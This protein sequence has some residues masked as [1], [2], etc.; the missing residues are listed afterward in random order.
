MSHIVITGKELE[1]ITKNQRVSL[2]FYECSSEFSL[3]YVGGE[4]GPFLNKGT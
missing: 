4:Q 3:E 2:T 1:T